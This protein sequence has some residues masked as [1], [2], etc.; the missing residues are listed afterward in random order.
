MD[1]MG[2]VTGH[3]DHTGPRTQQRDG[4]IQQVNLGVTIELNGVVLRH[5]GLHASG[6]IHHQYVES[7]QLALDRVEHGGDRGGI[8]EIRADSDR[9]S[10]GRADL[11][12][13]L[14]RPRLLVA[15]VD[16]DARAG[17]GEVTDGVCADAAG[18]AGDEGTKAV[19]RTGGEG[20]CHG[21]TPG[22]RGRSR[23]RATGDDNIKIRRFPGCWW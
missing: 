21:K 15:V 10:A 22:F 5:A 14:V 19:E 16:Y 6:C 20:I 7:A 4:R 23:R 3:E 1:E 2:L 9:G 18:G 13:E 8:G 11:V 17:F 12:H